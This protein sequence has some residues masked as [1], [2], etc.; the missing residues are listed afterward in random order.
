M[1]IWNNI[2]HLEKKSCDILTLNQIEIS[3]YCNDKLELRRGHCF[4]KPETLKKWNL[5]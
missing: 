5:T 4:S 3:V 2:K 1:L